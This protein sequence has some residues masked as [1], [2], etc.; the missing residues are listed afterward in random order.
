MEPEI[1]RANKGYRNKVVTIYVLVALAI[2]GLFRWGYPKLVHF[3]QQTDPRRAILILK[4]ILTALFV[5][6]IP[7]T[8]YL[9]LLGRRIY[10]YR[11]YPLPGARVL[12]D[13]KRVRGEP[14][15]RMGLLSMVA[16]VVLLG[17]SLAGIVLSCHFVTRLIDTGSAIHTAP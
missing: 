11:E 13:T 1:V 10:V 14:A 2:T 12:R 9:Y 6:L 8:I 3:L 16:A 4:D 7:I 15:R 17:L 5:G